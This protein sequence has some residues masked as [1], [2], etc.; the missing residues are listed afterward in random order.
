MSDP[1]RDTDPVTGVGRVIH[2][3]SGETVRDFF[4]PEDGFLPGLFSK[5]GAAY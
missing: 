4:S 1:C 5:R 2:F 3:F